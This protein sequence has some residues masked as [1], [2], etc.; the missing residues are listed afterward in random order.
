LIDDVFT[1]ASK[2]AKGLHGGGSQVAVLCSNAN[3][4][5]SYREAGR[6][7][8][9]YVAVTSREDIRELRYARTRCVFSM[10]DYV[11]GLQF[12]TVFLINVDSAD[13]S[14]E[15]VSLGA[16]RRYVSRIYLGAS[17]AENRLII[18]SS[19]ERGGP[20]TILNWPLR[21]HSLTAV[22]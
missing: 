10:P 13:L 19:R 9:M 4:F 20:S 18:A 14:D 2:F 1:Q 17:R 11:A 15:H 7:K 21:S 16:R 12:D 8:N 5:D 22:G 6:I 3:L